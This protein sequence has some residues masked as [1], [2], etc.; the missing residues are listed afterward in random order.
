MG[1][2]PASLCCEEGA[3]EI[4]VAPPTEI[5]SRTEEPVATFELPR[6]IEGR[7]SDTSVLKNMKWV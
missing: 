4:A 5:A 3:T 1:P 2:R 6:A 7:G